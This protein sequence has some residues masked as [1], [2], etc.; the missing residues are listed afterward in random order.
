MSFALPLLSISTFDELMSRCKYPAVAIATRVS[1]K[2]SLSLNT[3][4]PLTFLM[5]VLNGQGDLGGQQASRLFPEGTLLANEVPDG[6]FWEVL[7]HEAPADNGVTQL[8]LLA[9]RRETLGIQ[10]SGIEI[11]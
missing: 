4:D 11:I 8:Q 6:A 3:Q 5:H 9:F 1:D 2:E 10:L 7:H